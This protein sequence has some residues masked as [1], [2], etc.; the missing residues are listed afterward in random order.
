MNK[1][2]DENL[3]KDFDDLESVAEKVAKNIIEEITHLSREETDSRGEDIISF[4]EEA[5]KR[6]IDPLSFY[7]GYHV[8]ESWCIHMDIRKRKKLSKSLKIYL[9]KQFIDDIFG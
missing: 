2:D 4:L 6:K 7:L 5:F 8:G 9:S 1:K 3:G